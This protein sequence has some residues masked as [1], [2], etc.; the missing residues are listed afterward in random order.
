MSK[1]ENCKRH[2]VDGCTKCK[3][4]DM[5]KVEETK[6]V[7]LQCPHCGFTTSNP[8]K[9]SEHLLEKHGG[10]E[11]TTDMVK[12]ALMDRFSKKRRKGLILPI[13]TTRSGIFPEP[14]NESLSDSEQLRFMMLQW[15]DERN[16]LRPMVMA[17]VR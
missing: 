3:F 1:C 14:A 5:K 6:S 13:D 17:A 2:D 4:K 15:L 10:K 8:R 12:R 16:A 11:R 9:L 7:W